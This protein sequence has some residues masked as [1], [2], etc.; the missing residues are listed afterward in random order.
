MISG[1]THAKEKYLREHLMPYIMVFDNKIGGLLMR[2]VL[3]ISTLALAFL[4]VFLIAA[5]AFAATLPY[6]QRNSV[7]DLSPTK[8]QINM[9][10][11]N[12]SRYLFTQFGYSMWRVENGLVKDKR[13]ATEYN[14]LS[15]TSIGVWY[16]STKWYGTL[17]P[18]SQYSYEIYGKHSA[19]TVISRGTFRTPT[20]GL[21]TNK[22]VTNLGTNSAQI[23]ASL[24]NAYR[25]NVSK[26]GYELWNSALT[27]RIKTRTEMINYNVASLPIWYTT[28]DICGLAAS[29]KYMYRF[30]AVVGNETVMGPWGSFTTAAPQKPSIVSPSKFPMAVALKQTP[31]ECTLYSAAMVMRAKLALA[32]K[33]YAGVH[34][35][36]KS[37]RS[38]AWGSAGLNWTIN[39][40]NMTMISEN[41][42]GK[43]YD[44]RKSYLIS[45]LASHPEGIVLYASSRSGGRHAVVLT[46][47]NQATDTFY[48]VDPAPDFFTSAPRALT[49]AGLQGTTQ[50]GILS[51]AA[52]RLWYL[53]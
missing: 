5:P 18:N 25:Y 52:I 6:S 16:A 42:S 9:T 23:N 34:P 19:G 46:H 7:T 53:K 4:L 22:A 20:I 37:F 50:K 1:T 43:T 44:A 41:I 12:P 10:I 3:K 15:S 32:G 2:R 11:A 31:S 17:R 14:R 8:A 21:L 13:S 39:H 47:Y 38:A 35:T 45:K 36:N 26:C 40:S 30:F 24:S 51:V 49:T 27:K 29:T 28:K 33:A 48:C